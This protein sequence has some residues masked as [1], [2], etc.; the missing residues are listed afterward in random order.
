MKYLSSIILLTSFITFGCFANDRVSPTSVV[1]KY[2]SSS[3]STEI[4]KDGTFS[5]S[6]ENEGVS[7]NGSV[8]N[9]GSDHIVNIAVD[10][11]TEFGYQTVNTTI[12]IKKEENGT[13]RTIGGSIS[14]STF[15]DGDGRV[16]SESGPVE[17]MISLTLK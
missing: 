6:N 14:E 16:I 2:D 4:Q 8:K 10:Q 11:K 15:L 13:P 9:K 5:G 12:L 1:L 7:F 17:R 3:I